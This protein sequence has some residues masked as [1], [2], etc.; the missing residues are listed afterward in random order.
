MEGAGPS[1]RRWQRCQLAD[2]E[3]EMLLRDLEEREERGE[4]I[5]DLSCSS[6]S[7]EE[8]EFSEDEAV[9]SKPDSGQSNT[10]AGNAARVLGEKLGDVAASRSRPRRTPEPQ[11]SCS[12]ID[13]EETE[14][15]DV[16]FATFDKGRQ[17]SAEVTG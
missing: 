6:Q 5:S 13:E 14:I 8:S 12:S 2:Q 3:W 11:I 17:E 9:E 16:V 7:E 15:P 1:K 10:D 4:N